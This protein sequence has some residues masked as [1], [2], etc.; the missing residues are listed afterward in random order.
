[1]R[2][3]SRFE[4]Q[5]GVTV[6]R[7]ELD[8]PAIL[9]QALADVEAVIH[10]AA[11]VGDWGPKEEYRQANVE[12]LRKLLDACKGLGLARFVHLSSL[13]VYPPRHHYGSDETMPLPK[14]HRDGYTQSKVEAEQLA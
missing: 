1:M 14:K 11:K 10:C 2:D 5:E 4:N 6:F 9:R 8:D 3:L 7:G 12:T 13:G